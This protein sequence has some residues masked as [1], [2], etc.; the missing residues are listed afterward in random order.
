M[1]DIQADEETNRL[2]AELTDIYP[3]LQS[4]AED[5]ERLRRP[6]PVVQDALRDSGDNWDMLGLRA[7]ARLDYRAEEV[8]VE[9]KYVFG[10]G[11]ENLRRGRCMSRVSPALP[12][13]LHQAAWSQGVRRRMLDELRELTR[14]KDPSEGSP[15]TSDEFFAEFARHFSHVRGTMARPRETWRDNESTLA[16]GAQLN[17]EQETMSRCRMRTVA[18]VTS[19]LGAHAQPAWTVTSSPNSPV[20]PTSVPCWRTRTGGGARPTPPGAGTAGA[21]SMC[22]PSYRVPRRCCARASTTR[23]TFRR[24]AGNSPLVPPSSRS[25]P[26]P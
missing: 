22:G 8:L 13:G 17:D 6:T 10:I 11:P 19:F 24:W 7:T 4:E 1:V 26:T 14:R 23:V 25:S 5:S 15:V 16:T 12:A 9:D 20:T 21:T 2:L 18:G 3:L